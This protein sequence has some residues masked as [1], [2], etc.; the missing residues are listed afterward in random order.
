[1]KVQKETLEKS[2]GG[3]AGL[4]EEFSLGKIFPDIHDS[5]E[6]KSFEFNECNKE[7]C[8]RRSLEIQ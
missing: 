7:I 2:L 6:F 4:S 3:K 5:E 1:M 8:L